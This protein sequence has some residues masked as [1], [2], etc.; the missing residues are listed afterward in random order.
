MKLKTKKSVVTRVNEHSESQANETPQKT[1]G[2]VKRTQPKAS[3][4][5]FTN[6]NY[7]FLILFIISCCLFT[8]LFSSFELAN[9]DFGFFSGLCR[10]SFEGDLMVFHRGSKY[11]SQILE[12]RSFKME[13]LKL[14]PTLNAQNDLAT[15]Y[16]SNPGKIWQNWLWLWITCLELMKMDFSQWFS[17]IFF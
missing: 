1:N 13:P 3:N 17:R 12:I 2:K 14:D 7:Y 6:I 4:L 8:Q 15:E 9:S 16:T 5:L 10:W 11:V